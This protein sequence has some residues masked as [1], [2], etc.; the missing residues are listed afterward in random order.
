[1]FRI[2]DCSPEDLQLKKRFCVECLVLG[3]FKWL[4]EIIEGVGYS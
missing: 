1:M 2:S 3:G 4:R